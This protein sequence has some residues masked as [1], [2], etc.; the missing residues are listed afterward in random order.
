M[1]E[2]KTTLGY[3]MLTLLA[4]LPWLSSLT[5]DAVLSHKAVERALAQVDAPFARLE[6]VAV[7]LR[8]ATVPRFM[9][10]LLKMP[11]TP[12]RLTSL[13]VRLSRS[14]R[15]VLSVIAGKLAALRSLQVDFGREHTV[16]DADEITSLRALTQLRKVWLQGWRASAGGFTGEHLELLISSLPHLCHIDLSL[17]TGVREFTVQVNGVTWGNYGSRWSNDTKTCNCDRVY[18]YRMY[19]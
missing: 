12:Q 13:G 6:E 5:V 7:W 4:R 19:R 14:D 3:N 1:L 15:L 9:A 10:L 8:A 11:G 18:M 16:I 2:M 17:T